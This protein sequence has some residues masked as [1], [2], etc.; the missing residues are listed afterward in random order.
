[1]DFERLLEEAK[2]VRKKS[3]SPYSGFAVGTAIEDINGTVFS[4]CNVENLAFPSGLCAE[5]TAIFKAVSEVGSS[6]KLKK[7]VIYTA[8]DAIT[9]PCGACRQVIEE[10]AIPETEIFCVGDG[11]NYLRIK[12]S[13]LHLYPTRIAKLE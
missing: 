8:T 11:N 12:F 9:T 10:F 7:V 2:S 3:Y 1:M 5:R 4:G 6:F 13:D